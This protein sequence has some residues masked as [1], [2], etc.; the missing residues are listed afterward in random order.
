VKSRTFGDLLNSIQDDA[1]RDEILDLGRKV[2]EAAQP[3]RASSSVE[4]RQLLETMETR[5]RWHFRAAR[6]AIPGLEEL[7]RMIDEHFK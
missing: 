6:Y 2:R 4:R 5:I 1:G 7:Q 3:G